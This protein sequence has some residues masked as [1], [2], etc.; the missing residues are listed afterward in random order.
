MTKESVSNDHRNDLIARLRSHPSTVPGLSETVCIEAV[1][2]IERLQRELAETQKLAQFECVARH[3]SYAECDRLLAALSE[4]LELLRGAQTHLL[5][6]DN[7]IWRGKLDRFVKAYG[8][9]NEALH[10][11]TTIVSV[12]TSRNSDPPCIRREGDACLTEHSKEANVPF[13]VTDEMVTRFLG[14]RLPDD[15]DPDCGITFKKLNHPTSWP[16][17]TNLLNATQARA[18]LEHVLGVADGN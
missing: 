12:P 1:Y 7:S 8:G 3:E 14:W 17:G 9:A 2:E 10:G 15:F 16:I 11:N 5:D 4:A 18:M 6:G 13:K